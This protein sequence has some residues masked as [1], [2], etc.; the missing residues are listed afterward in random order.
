M[1]PASASLERLRV[2]QAN[3]DR[4]Q[5]CPAH[6]FDLRSETRFSEPVCHHGFV[7]RACKGTAD[8]EYIMTFLAGARQAGGNLALMASKEVL[9][10]CAFA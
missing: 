6:F 8:A 5:S 7:C 3:R 2:Y 10:R 4:L 1:S 9:G